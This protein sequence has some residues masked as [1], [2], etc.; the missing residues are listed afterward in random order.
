MTKE[1][2]K[3][4]C[5]ILACL[6]PLACFAD[7]ARLGK[8]SS[9]ITH[10]LDHGTLQRT[11]DMARVLRLL[12]FEGGPPDIDE[13]MLFAD[14]YFM[15]VLYYE[16]YDCKNRRHRILDATA[17]ADRMMEGKIIEHIK[18]PSAWDN[19]SPQTLLSQI[20]SIVCQATAPRP[21]PQ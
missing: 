13:K 2:F 8:D 10:Y 7:W 4:I 18:T 16:E 20:L 17:Y 19:I 21:T 14:E 5:V 11:G 6:T 15:S 3:K 1:C 9:E 12:D